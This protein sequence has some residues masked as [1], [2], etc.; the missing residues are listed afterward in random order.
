MPRPGTRRSSFLLALGPLDLF[1]PR[2]K[3][4]DDYG[5]GKEHAGGDEERTL[6][7]VDERVLRVV[8]ERGALGAV[9]G[10]G[11]R[12]GCDRALDC[13]GGRTRQL[14]GSGGDVVAIAA[15]E[16]PRVETLPPRGWHRAAAN[17]PR[18]VTGPEWFE[19]S[20]QSRSSRIG[21]SFRLLLRRR[22]G[23]RRGFLS[24]SLP[25]RSSEARA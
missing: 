8:Q 19:S 12:D 14:R 23:V 13:V 15:V 2:R 17:C 11:L 5:G 24:T 6:E 1:A 7:A 25:Y 10:C 20:A 21:S 9:F 3:N 4:G 16:V 22:E 18:R